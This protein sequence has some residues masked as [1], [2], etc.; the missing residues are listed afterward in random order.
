MKELSHP[1]RQVCPKAPKGWPRY[2]CTD[3]VVTR[4]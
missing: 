2:L 1:A 4:A 3:Q